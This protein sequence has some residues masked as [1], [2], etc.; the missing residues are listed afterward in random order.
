MNLR[1]AIR[2][3]AVSVWRQR[4]RSTLAGLG[5]T[6]GVAV[7]VA[8]VAVG[9]GAEHAVLRSLRSMGTDLVVVSSGKVLVVAGRPKQTGNV[10]TL[11]L[12]DAAVVN[13]GAV[14]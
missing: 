1:R 2:N 11:T 14:A 3:A 6:V 7:L 13:P 8:M 10:T 12:Q 4:R 5:V 9:Q